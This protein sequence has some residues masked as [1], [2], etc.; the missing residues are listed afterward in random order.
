MSVAF[1]RAGTRLEFAGL[2]AHGVDRRLVWW[3]IAYS[4]GPAT[5]GPPSN[6]VSFG[7]DE[8]GKVFWKTFGRQ[9]GSRLDPRTQSSRTTSPPS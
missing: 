9:V 2:A 8:S 7:E 5:A 3:R 6:L 4:Q 1:F